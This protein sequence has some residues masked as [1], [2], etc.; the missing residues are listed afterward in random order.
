MTVP[1]IVA[2]VLFLLLAFVLFI[3]AIVAFFMSRNRSNVAAAPAPYVPPPAPAPRVAQPVSA[4]PA[5]VPYAVPV[6]PVQPAVQP[7]VPP[8]AGSYSPPAT[9]DDDKTVMTDQRRGQLFGA[10][11]GTSGPL[12]GRVFPIDASGFYIGRDRATSQVVIDSPSISKRHVWI[13]VKDGAVVAAD[14]SS[15]NGTFLND[16]NAAITEAKLTPGDTLILG[17][18]VARFEYRL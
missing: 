17:G 10:L 14:Q 6:Q 12:A 13:G 15:T 9:A 5:P 1:L 16:P 8:M 11:H 18:D 7:I 2:G 3:A 4:A